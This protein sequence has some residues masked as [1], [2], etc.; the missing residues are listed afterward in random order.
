[1]WVYVTSAGP[2]YE[3]DGVAINISE[4]KHLSPFDRTPLCPFR[5]QL[6]ISR[7]FALYHTGGLPSRPGDLLFFS[8]GFV[9]YRA[10]RLQ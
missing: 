5:H 3:G 2:Y 4:L 7:D 6:L 8:C 9:R 10:K 1:M